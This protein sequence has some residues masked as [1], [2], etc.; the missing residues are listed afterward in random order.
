[1]ELIMHEQ[2]TNSC[3]KDVV[4]HLMEHSPKDLE[5]LAMTAKQYL[6]AHNKKL[7][8]KGASAKQETG[9]YGRMESTMERSEE[10]VRCYCCNG[11]GHQAV[12]CPSTH[13]RTHQGE[14]PSQG[15]NFHCFR[16]RAID[17]E[18]RDCW[19]SQPAPQLRAGSGDRLSTQT[20][21]V[22]CMMQVLKK[23]KEDKSEFEEEWLK[24]KI[25][26]L[27]GACMETEVKDNLL[28]LPGRVGGRT[29]SVLKDTG[30]IDVIVTSLVD[31]ARLTGEIAHMMMVDQTIKRAPIARINIDTLYYTGV[32]EALYLRDLLFDLIIRNILGARR[33]DNPNPKWSMSAA[34]ATRVQERASEGSKPLNVQK[35][36]GKVAVLKK[37]LMISQEDD[38]SLRKFQNV[39]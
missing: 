38:P 12:E 30:C 7:S 15:R 20:H 13:A 9:W 37:N 29:V 32:V 27:N 14:A 33:P 11:R 34:V 24:L 2:F 36:A 25:K 19:S 39:K 17:H 22:A 4:I 31:E 1:M 26:V 18:A 6:V 3:S 23:L 10:V 8:S 21:R 5:K 35:V 16:C 28:V